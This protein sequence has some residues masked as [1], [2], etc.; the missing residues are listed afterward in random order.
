MSGLNHK[1]PGT[2]H[3]NVRVYKVIKILGNALVLINILTFYGVSAFK[4]DKSGDGNFG[5][6]SC[7]VTIFLNVE[8]CLQC[9]CVCCSTSAYALCSAA[10]AEANARRNSENILQPNQ[11]LPCLT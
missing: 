5:H 4:N 2:G 8:Q 9:I 7:S 10:N 11:S 6:F 3:T 1:E